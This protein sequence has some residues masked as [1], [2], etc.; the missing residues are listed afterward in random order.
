MKAK[1]G[2][3]IIGR[4]KS[5]RE[6]ETQIDRLAVGFQELEQN[7]APLSEGNGFHKFEEM[8]NQPAESDDSAEVEIQPSINYHQKKEE[9]KRI[10]FRRKL[11]RVVNILLRIR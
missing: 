4:I 6:I 1:W 3:F 7:Q 2:G 9:R 5:P 11:I 8:G 10:L